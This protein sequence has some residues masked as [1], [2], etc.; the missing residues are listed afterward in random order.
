[1]AP[2]NVRTGLQPSLILTFA[3]VGLTGLLMLFHADFRGI[4]HFHEW[5]SVVFLALCIF[6]LYLNWK[7]L[8]AHLKN[9]PVLLSVIGISLLSALLLFSGGNAKNGGYGRSGGG[10]YNQAPYKHNR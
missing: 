2:K 1:M 3:I 10:H 5:M 8:L 9:G 7:V 4:K 6:H